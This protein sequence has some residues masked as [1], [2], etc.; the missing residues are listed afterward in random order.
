MSR[1]DTFGSQVHYKLISYNWTIQIQAQ[2]LHLHR[3]TY[4]MSIMAFTAKNDTPSRL[5]IPFDVENACNLVQHELEEIAF[6]DFDAEKH[7]NVVI[8]HKVL[9][10]TM[11]LQN[12]A[13]L[14]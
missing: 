9:L 12:I 11:S 3:G 10:I 1:N 14:L 8:I 4:V 2:P 6:S 5:N 13:W 7:S